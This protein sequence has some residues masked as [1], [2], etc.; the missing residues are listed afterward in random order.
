[1]ASACN[2]LE[3]GLGSQP[4]IETRVW[5]WKYQ[6]LAPR[7]VVSDTGPGPLA[8]QKIISI[9]IE[10]GEISKMFIKREKEYSWCG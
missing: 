7:S 1:M 10:G 5:R 9:N 4:E 2:G 8:L 6:I 3:Q